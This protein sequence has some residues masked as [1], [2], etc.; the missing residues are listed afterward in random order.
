[1]PLLRDALQVKD[2]VVAPDCLTLYGLSRLNEH[3][4]LSMASSG[5]RVL[6]VGPSWVGDMVMAQSLFKAIKKAHTN[7]S[8]SVL[9]PAWTEPLVA[10]MPE[11]NDCVGSTLAHGKLMI[12]ERIALARQ[13]KERKFDQAF[14]LPRSL[15]SALI[16]LWSGIP[17]RTGYLGEMRWGLINDVRPL[18]K[19]ALPMTVQRFVNLAAPSE[20]SP[21]PISLRPTL[22]TDHQSILAT[23][24]KFQLAENHKPVLALCPGAEYG[25]AKQ[26]PAEHWSAT[27]RRFLSTGW[28]VF[29]LGSEK[30]G[31]IA[32]RIDAATEREC[33]NLAGRTN[34]SEAI[35]LLAASD[36]VVT[37]DSGLMHVA[38]ALDRPLVAIYGS[39]STK[40]TPPLSDSARIVSA[41]LS[42]SPCFKRTCPLG[43]TRCLKDI[44]ADQVAGLVDELASTSSIRHA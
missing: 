42:C 4:D 29:L 7:T 5:R 36:V 18:D 32:R 43:H 38:A 19:D 34:L 44:S 37:N 39:S 8:I 1:M 30:D 17:Q 21:L 11:V 3:P 12:R 25:P 31:D 2:R 13:L 24:A 41:G 35:E 10:R 14:V 40:S 20:I 15:K 33:R 27:A 23:L 16:P 6:V 9:A 26:W 28:E 22:S